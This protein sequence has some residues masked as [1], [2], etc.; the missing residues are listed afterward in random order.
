MGRGTEWIHGQLDVLHCL[1]GRGG[2][3]LCASS[4]RAF[5]ERQRAV[6]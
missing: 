3:A 1:T 5:E 4:R 2:R 6:L